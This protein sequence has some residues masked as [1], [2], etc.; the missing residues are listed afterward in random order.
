LKIAFDPAKRDRTL[1]HRKL[2]FAPAPEVFAGRTAT[3]VDDR[4]DYAAGAAPAGDIGRRSR[5]ADAEVAV[6]PS[7]SAHTGAFSRSTR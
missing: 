3:V 7:A 4:H 6:F 5:T 1:K 2:D